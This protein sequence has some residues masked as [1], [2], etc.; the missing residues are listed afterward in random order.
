MDILKRYW[1]W[2]LLGF[3]GLVLF[4]PEGEK[5]SEQRVAEDKALLEQTMVNTFH[6][7]MREQ[8]VEMGFD[9][10]KTYCTWRMSRVA[11]AH[12]EQN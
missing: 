11:A 1:A 2:G 10:L 7:C 9:S 4:W 6:Q 3:F 5:T 12:M 8:K